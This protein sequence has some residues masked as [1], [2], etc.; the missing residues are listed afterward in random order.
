M[1]R[2]ISM[3]GV[4][5]LIVIITG[6]V[7]LL[8]VSGD[9][10]GGDGENSTVYPEPTHYC[11]YLQEHKDKP[12]WDIQD[13]PSGKWN[14]SL[15]YYEM[16]KPNKKMFCKAGWELLPR[17]PEPPPATPN[18]KRHCNPHGCITI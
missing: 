18:A 13:H 8:G 3:K 16:D 1:A 11:N 6:M 14:D 4:I 5:P 9:P 2:G 10:I 7:F 17:P 15:C 12:C